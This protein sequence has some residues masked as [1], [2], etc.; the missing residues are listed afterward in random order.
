MKQL[1]QFLQ[2]CQ[3]CRNFTFLIQPY[4]EMKFVDVKNDVAFRKIFGNENKTVILISFLNAVL[5][6]EGYSRITEVTLL[7]PFQLPRLRGERASIIDVRA[8]D[9]TGATFIVEMQ[10]AEPDGFDKRVLYYSSKDYAGQINAGDDYPLL[11]PIYFIGILDFNYFK[12]EEYLSSH[13]IIDEATGENAFKDLKFRF[14]ELKKFNKQAHELENI[15]DKWTF[16]IKNALKLEVMPDNTDDEGLKE[17]YGE[18]AEHNWSR[19]AYD[20]YI[21]AGMREQDAKGV[22]TLAV[23]RAE[24]RVR[25]EERAKAEAEKAEMKAK[26]EAKEVEMI[27]EMY[28]EGM[29]IAKIAK[30]AKKSPEQVQ[31]I[32]ADHADKK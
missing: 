5:G 23:D 21:Y 9:K 6:L 12:G 15:I 28:A 11:R 2:S 27:L 7:D 13:S 30:F 3:N 26:A 25:K 16:F 17:A 24:K 10:V 14:I 20:A 19:E 8:T 22:I 29:P 31:Q 18:A 4:F 32:I 1:R